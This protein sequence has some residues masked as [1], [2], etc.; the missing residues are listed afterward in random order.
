MKLVAYETVKGEFVHV[1]C[2]D[3]SWKGLLN[4]ATFLLFITLMM[5]T[6]GLNTFL[7]LIPFIPCLALYLVGGYRGYLRKPRWLLMK[8]KEALVLNPEFS[9][10]YG[11]PASPASV[12]VLEDRDIERLCF[13]REIFRVPHRFGTTRHHFISLDI[14]LTQPLTEE[15][16][17][18]IVEGQHRFRLSRKEGPFPFRLEGEQV[19]RIN[20]AWI[21][22]AENQAEK[23]LQ[24]WYP[25][26][27]RREVVFPDWNVMNAQ[28]QR[29]YVA[30]LWQMGMSWEAEVINHRFL[31]L[32]D[33]HWDALKRQ[34]SGEDGQREEGDGQE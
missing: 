13:T 14:H 17:K 23:A 8:S 2:T 19:L 11:A 10:G 9:G 7:P 12:M 28:L 3:A 22:P 16:R 34:Y 5:R 25:V 1:R 30:E 29:L 20:W 32:S 26:I 31:R 33:T 24:E 27:R 6:L 18:A 21:S 4:M 15:L